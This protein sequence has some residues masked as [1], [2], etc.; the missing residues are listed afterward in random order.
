MF[1]VKTGNLFVEL[2]YG[3]NRII[4]LTSSIFLF[5]DNWGDTISSIL[6]S[7]INE[8]KK[9]V[10]HRSYSWNIYHLPD[11]LCVGSIITWMTTPRS[12]IWGSGIVYPEQE[13]SAIPS[14][15][16]AVRG[17]LTRNYLLQRNIPCPEV[18]GDPA[19][20]FPR[21]YCPE[22]KKRYKMGIIPHFR[23]MDHSILK[24]VEIELDN[25]LIINVRDVRDWRTFIKQI[26]MCEFIVSS[27]LHGIIISDA[28]KIPNCWIKFVG[29]ED[30]K[31][32]FIDYF[33]SV[34]KDIDEPLLITNIDDMKKSFQY[35][36]YWKEPNIDLDLLMSNCP[37]IL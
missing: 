25:I 14:D 31:F 27:S 18:Y 28:Y 7:L 22:V 23:D 20:L 6:V 13:I 35:K 17:P 5:K 2:Y 30:K 1:F 19:L 8:K 37:F 33:M 3:K 26:C 29:G 32:A 9:K 11:Y 16:L 12:V 24:N 15:V 34:K 4:I 10:I 36:Q 21:Y